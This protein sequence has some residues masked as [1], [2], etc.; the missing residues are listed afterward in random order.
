MLRMR[1]YPLYCRAG[2]RYGGQ[3][4]ENQG[5]MPAS[6][7]RFP[8]VETYQDTS[9][10]G[11]RICSGAVTTDARPKAVGPDGVTVHVRPERRER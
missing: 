7:R 4:P 8:T 2:C 1:N 10:I 6:D 5:R 11:N 3:G 9:C